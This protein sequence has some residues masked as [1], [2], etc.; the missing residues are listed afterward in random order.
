MASMLLLA[1]C[2][3]IYGRASATGGFGYSEYKIDDR[4][5]Q[6]RF[7]GIP[8]L[9]R[10]QVELF[11]LYR[12]AYLAREK[13]Y[14][15]FALAFPPAVRTDAFKSLPAA[16][17]ALFLANT[18]ERRNM[19]RHVELIRAFFVPGPRYW[20][21][22]GVM[23]VFHESLPADVP[24]AFRAQVIIDMLQ[25]LVDAAHEAERKNDSGPYKGEDDEIDRRRAIH[26]LLTFGLRHAAGDGDGHAPFARR[27]LFFAQLL[28]PPDLGIDLFGGLFTD[29]AGVEQHKI[30]AFGPVG[31]LVSQRTQKV[32]HP[33]AVID[34]HLTAIGLDVELF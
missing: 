31:N 13:G 24:F 21:S 17:P 14:E 11:W 22:R 15:L 19:Y 29:M 23:R 10:E 4:T 27:D 34:I 33:L 3:T 1:A 2:V 7:A 30:R 32:E 9:T 25:P 26:D 18:R 6:V 12:C 5:Y 28:Q 16:S 20:V 8:P